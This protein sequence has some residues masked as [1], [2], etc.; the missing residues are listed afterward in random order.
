MKKTILDINNVINEYNK[1][2]NI[3]K[4]AEMFSTSH[5]RISKLLKENNIE[6]NNI[7]KRKDFTE[8]NISNMIYDYVEKHLTMENISKKYEIRI[9]RLR[10]I[11]KDRNIK[12]SKWN[13][14]I[15]KDKKNII[16]KEKKQYEYKKCP[17]CDWKTKDVHNKSHSYQKHLFKKHNIDVEQHLKEFPEDIFYLKS[18]SEKKHLVEC[19]ICGKLL[20]LIDKRHLDKHGIT[21]QEYIEKY[22]DNNLI[23]KNT[24]LKLQVCLQ[25][26]NENDSW[27]RKTS[28]YE[29]NIKDFLKTNNIIFE[30]H[31]RKL[32]NGLEI[33][34]LSNNIGIEFNGNKYHTDWFGG[35]TKYYH[36]NKTIECNKQGIKL[37]QIFEDE[38][39][40]H[41]DIVLNKISHIVG[42]Q[43]DLPKIM[44]RKCKIELIDKDIAESFLNDYHIQGFA[45]STVYLG[46]V[47]NNNLIGVMTFKQNFKGSDKW[48]LTR[49][50]SDY[51]Y[52]CQGVGGKMFNWFIK[53]YNPTEVKSFADRRW[54]LDK[55]NNLYTKLG[56]KLV[57]ELKPEYR[58]YNPKVDKYKRF[59]KFGF[60]K[61]ILH[62]KYGFPLSM[63]ETEMVK[64]LGYDRI[65]DC[66]LF[67]FVW[68]R[69]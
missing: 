19:K 61:Q 39:V 16:I 46:V 44:G 54:T 28:K 8:E 30:E 66:G 43:Q 21:K 26:M 14:H 9:K 22:G 40:E 55:E 57:E 27:E 49:F 51:H 2:K 37:L 56:F 17:Y 42:I 25:K 48:E 60:R 38:F 31:N 15:K 52:V 20:H 69:E 58:Y 62:R 1:C 53:N 23:T 33:D 4:V 5:I 35:K 47:Y 24:K 67:K 12:I 10:K 32:L 29:S 45:R 59:H 34:I 7:G 13:G 68:K 41:K 63:T 64:E 3:H 50:A 6:I 18:V 65:W 36:L 11:F